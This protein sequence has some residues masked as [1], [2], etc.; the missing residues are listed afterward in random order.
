[1][2]TLRPMEEN[3]VGPRTQNNVHCDDFAFFSV[4]TFM[5]IILDVVRS[6]DILNDLIA[7]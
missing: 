1:M 4:L 7:F 3:E 2:L 6:I 5:I